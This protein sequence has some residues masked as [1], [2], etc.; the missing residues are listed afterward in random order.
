MKVNHK[1]WP[2]LEPKSINKMSE[3]FNKNI[4][5][6]V[7]RDMCYKKM[8][9]AWY[10]FFIPD[11]LKTQEICDKVVTRNPRML[12]YIPDKFKTQEMYIKAVEVGP[13]QLRNVHDEFK[14]QKMCIKAV[15]EAP[16]MLR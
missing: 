12:D 10:T 3:L 15:K 9:P 13:F 8:L 2:S 1:I 7:I 4:F 14:T 5:W 6:Y 11:H 16:R